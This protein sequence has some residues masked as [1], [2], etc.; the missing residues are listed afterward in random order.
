[1]KVLVG[2]FCL[3]G[4]I[5]NGHMINLPAAE[6]PLYGLMEQP[7]PV[8]PKHWTES[9]GQI[10]GNCILGQPYKPKSALLS[11]CTFWARHCI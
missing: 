1:M 4:K 3:G 8:I 9:R 7:E 10:M 5:I 6:K 2:I 11:C